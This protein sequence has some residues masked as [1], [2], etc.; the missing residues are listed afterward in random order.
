MTRVVV[1]GASMCEAYF[2]LGQNELNARFSHL[3]NTRAAFKGGKKITAPAQQLTNY[4]YYDFTEICTNIK[5]GIN[6]YPF[7]VIQLEKQA[8]CSHVTRTKLQNQKFQ[9]DTINFT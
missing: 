5:L 4:L 9:N 7:S 6:P 2:L 1:G 8:Q 3:A